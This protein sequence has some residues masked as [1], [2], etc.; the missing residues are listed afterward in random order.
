VE[1]SQ[2]QVIIQ[3]NSVLILL[4]WQIGFRIN[5]T[6]LQNKRAEYGK[7]IVPTVSAQLANK[8]G[9]NFEEKNFRRMMQF[10]DQFSDKQ[11]VVTLSRQ[12]SRSHFIELLP[13]TN[14]ALQGLLTSKK[15]KFKTS[16]NNF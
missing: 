13:I 7:Q 3:N 14:P 5:E 1:Q 16:S 12:L 8:Y 15:I 10:A 9:R 4:F 2:Q 11:I 6:I